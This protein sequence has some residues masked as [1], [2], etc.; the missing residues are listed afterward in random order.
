MTSEKLK[1]FSDLAKIVS[2]F[3]LAAVMVFVMVFRIA[4]AIEALTI[5][6]E[7]LC[8]LMEVKR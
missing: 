5:K 4:P 3:G 8:V 1:D 7:R 6:I 2:N